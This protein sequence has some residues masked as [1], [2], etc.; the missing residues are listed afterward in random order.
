MTML[1]VK[2]L[3]KIYSKGTGSQTIALNG[4]N[5]SLCE[6]E[7]V[8]IMGE[9][10]SGKTTLLN[11]V[12]TLDKPSEGEVYIG[13]KNIG[14]FKNNELASFRRNELGF[15]FQDFNLLDTF[16]T[17]DNILLPL[18]LSGYSY[19]KMEK[20]LMPLSEVLGIE[21]LLNKFPYEISGGQKQR[22]AIARA[23]ITNPKLML[24][25]EPTGA[26]DSGSADMIMKTFEKINNS[27]QTI[28]V[29]THSVRAAAFAKRVLFIK[30][31]KVYNEIYKGERSNNEF[32]ETIGKTQF[33]MRGAEDEK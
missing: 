9:S 1:E 22:V 24:A 12:S 27:G 6:G 11:M 32:M 19:D 26:L 20:K 23:M 14:Q 15:V 3:T 28:M 21:A 25:D 7:F 13:G 8:A 17:K 30:D 31:G 5:F 33:M 16:N 18:V 10:G 2:N 4:I 29:V